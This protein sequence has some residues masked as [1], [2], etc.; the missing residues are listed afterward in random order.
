MVS[1]ASEHASRQDHDGE[2]DFAMTDDELRQTGMM[3]WCQV[4][5]DVLPAWIAELDVRAS[6]DIVQALHQAVDA[7]RFGY[8][9]NRCGE[10]AD[11]L[12]GFL[13]RRFSWSP[14][15]DS[16]VST[17]DVI[18]GVMLAIEAL[19]P[20]GPVVV[21]VP[22]YP[23]FIDAVRLAKRQL[24]A[25]PC[26]SD[27]T[28][29]VLDL[30]AIS[31][32]LAA[33]A[34][35]ILLTNP[36]NPLGRSWTSREL[37][38][39]RNVADAYGARVISDEVHA[40]LVLSGAR[41]VPYAT[42]DPENHITVFA[43]SKAWNLP[44]LKC[45]QIITGNPIDAARLRALP[46]VANRGVS[47]LGVVAS[48][49]AYKTGDAWLDGL[50][51]HLGARRHQFGSLLAQHLPQLSWQP[52]EASFLA[53]VDARASGSSK[54]AAAAEERGRVLVS[55]GVAFSPR[56]ATAV[57]TAVPSYGDFVR[58]NIGTSAE[59]LARIVARLAVAWG[60]A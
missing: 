43:A 5:P 50:V 24:I 51:R 39:L 14:D 33:G 21:P 6:S 46:R 56:D 13:S 41:H 49:A 10:L 45:A 19:G 30:D 7:G 47:S 54:P 57:G 35:T 42:V 44:G 25:V 36:H 1:M 18:V 60:S 8:P 53:W 58:V 2:P 3:K 48:V 37:I 40:P 27:G 9:S 55:D 22:C 52:M 11:A 31:R 28:R 4:P 26:T 20:P 12:S 17:G 15:P 59:R 34:G 16:I 29:T 23:P 38:D 32:E